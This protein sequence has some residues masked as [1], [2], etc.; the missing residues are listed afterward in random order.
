MSSSLPSQRAGSGPFRKIEFQKKRHMTMNF[1]A[2]WSFRRSEILDGARTSYD[3]RQEDVI[4]SCVQYWISYRR[5]SIKFW[6][7]GC[8][9]AKRYWHLPLLPCRSARSDVDNLG[10]GLA[11]KCCWSALFLSPFA[12]G[13]NKS[14]GDRVR[15]D[16]VF[17]RVHKL[18]WP[19]I[20][21]AEVVKRTWSLFYQLY[22]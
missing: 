18:T 10:R 7:F 1:G 6:M 8:R 3:L 5:T 14:L 12:M 13:R 11:S 20:R 22:G 4:Q 2:C 16:G 15:K 19:G 21:T 17:M 9:S